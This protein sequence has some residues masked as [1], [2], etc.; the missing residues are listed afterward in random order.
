M[1]RNIVLLQYF[2]TETFQL[3]FWS[4]IVLFF[5]SIFPFWF[6]IFTISFYFQSSHKMKSSFTKS[7]CVLMTCFIKNKSTCSVSIS[8]LF[9]FGNRAM[10]W[11]KKGIVDISCWPGQR[12]VEKWGRKKEY[13]LERLS[14]NN[15]G[16]NENSQR[17]VT[18]ETFLFPN[19]YSAYRLLSMWTVNGCLVISFCTWRRVSE[20]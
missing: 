11:K 20:S 1:V 4:T 14:K 9:Y 3:F 7:S 12:K 5:N 17:D 16:I 8:V 10:E 18:N 19:R 15:E 2:F 13:L 6:S